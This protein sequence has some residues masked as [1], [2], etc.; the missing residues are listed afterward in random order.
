LQF[1]RQPLRSQIQKEILARIVDGRLPAG[2]R[3]NETHLA[4]DLGLSR[5]PLREAMITMGAQGH[6]ISHMGKGFVIPQLDP[7]EFQ[8]ILDMLAALQPRALA[9][10]MPLMPA[11][12][13]E[14]SNTLTRGG[15]GL[16]RAA[17]GGQRGLALAG[18]IFNWNQALLGECPDHFL[19]TRITLLEELSARYWFA[20]GSRGWDTAE[21]RLSLAGCYEVIRLGDTRRACAIWGD[22]IAKFG[23]SAV[24]LLRD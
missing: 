4:A 1:Q 18:M 22:H 14:I 21:L 7:L 10:S 6:L 5:T 11:R 8:Q 13:L 12:L 20:A 23:E 2:Q 24:A 3:I 15:M 17:H 9:R 19:A 16:D